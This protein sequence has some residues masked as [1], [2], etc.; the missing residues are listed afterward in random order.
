MAPIAHAFSQRGLTP[1][2]VLTGQH[3]SLDP[4]DFGWG[5]FA[6]NGSTARVRKIPT[7]TSAQ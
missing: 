5:T 6:P 2:L 3:P 4:T 7:A 1:S